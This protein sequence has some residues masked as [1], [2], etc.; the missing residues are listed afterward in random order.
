MPTG[1]SFTLPLSVVSV[2]RDRFAPLQSGL[3]HSDSERRNFF[4]LIIKNFIVYFKCQAELFHEKDFRRHN[5]VKNGVLLEELMTRNVSANFDL[6][7][8]QSEMIDKKLER[9]KYADDLIVN[10]TVRIKRDKDFT[11]EATANFRWGTQAHVS[12]TD[13]DFA[14]ALNKMMDTLDVKIK[15]EKDKIQEK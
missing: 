15:K 12:A 1:I 6:D 3:R 11:A 2:A 13:F 5:A 8:K 4:I 7:T 14:A 10:L 9:I